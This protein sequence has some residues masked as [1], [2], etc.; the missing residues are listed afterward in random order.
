MTIAA[1]VAL[2]IGQYTA[3]VRIASG[4][5]I[6]FYKFDMFWPIDFVRHFLNFLSWLLWFFFWEYYIK[7]SRLLAIFR[8]FYEQERMDV[9]F[10]VLISFPL[11][12]PSWNL[13][14]SPKVRPNFFLLNIHTLRGRWRTFHIILNNT[15]WIWSN[16]FIRC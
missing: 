11:P 9:I 4:R 3:C 8:S 15:A 1:A 13:S 6:K 12:W 14:F 7:W 2:H 16:G 5:A 10:E